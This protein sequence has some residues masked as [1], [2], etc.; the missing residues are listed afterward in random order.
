MVHEVCIDLLNNANELDCTA[1]RCVQCGDIIDA[2]I[3]R[4]RQLGQP[5]LTSC[6]AL[7]RGYTLE[8]P[9]SH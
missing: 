7:T 4:N 2:V 1:Q 8:K 5:A 6:S 3:V 9:V